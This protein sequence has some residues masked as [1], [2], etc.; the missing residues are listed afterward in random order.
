MFHYLRFIFQQQITCIFALLT[1]GIAVLFIVLEHYT[2]EKSHPTSLASFSHRFHRVIKNICLQL[3]DLLII[4]A[5]RIAVLFYIS[6]VF[7]SENYSDGIL[8]AIGAILMIDF[9][10]YLSHILM[11]KFERL[12]RFHRIHHIDEFLDVSSAFRFHFFENMFSL[13]NRACLSIVFVLSPKFMA[14]F[15]LFES[16]VVIFQHSNIKL[17]EKVNTFVGYIFVT[18][19][20]HRIHHHYQLPYTDTNFGTIFSFWDRMFGTYCNS[21][22]NEETVIGLEDYNEQPLLRLLALNVVKSDSKLP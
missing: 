19:H 13:L 17:S 5:V 11:H 22:S 21:L 20:I 14:I 6:H 18:P 8:K 9:V 7:G 15:L 12:W 4:P 1:Y 2:P 10:S 16:L 3:I